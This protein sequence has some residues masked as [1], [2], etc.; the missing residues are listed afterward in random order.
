MND[1]EFKGKRILW[2]KGWDRPSSSIRIPIASK[3]PKP[4]TMTELAIQM[5]YT[6]EEWLA[7]G[8]ASG[9]TSI[10]TP[11]HPTHQH[12]HLIHIWGGGGGYDPDDPREIWKKGMDISPDLHPDSTSPEAVELW[13]ST[14]G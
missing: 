10:F 11:I 9:M 12:K 7:S 2:G 13:G 14:A 3:W 6:Y 5:R 4:P 1:I 8:K